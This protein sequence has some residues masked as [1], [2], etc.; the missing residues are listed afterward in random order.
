MKAWLG[1]LGMQWGFLSFRVWSNFVALL[2]RHDKSIEALQLLAAPPFP[3][4]RVGAQV[5][6]DSTSWPR[7]GQTR[8][9]HPKLCREGPARCGDRD[10]GRQQRRWTT[11]EHA[12]TL[13]AALYI[14]DELRL[15]TTVDQG[16][17]GQRIRQA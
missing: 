1:P 3:A 13:A 5:R 12:R 16:R 4:T 15:T 14:Y 9:V 7:V 11:I 17:G 8:A 6:R 10:R 2:C